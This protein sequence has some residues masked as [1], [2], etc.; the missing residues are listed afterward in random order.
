MK[1]TIPVTLSNFAYILDEDAYKKLNEY[2]EGIR[3]HFSITDSKE[4]TDEIIGDIESSIAEKFSSKLND[5]KQVISIEDVVELVK[6]MGSVEDIAG[7]REDVRDKIGE[8]NYNKNEEKTEKGKKK[9]LFRD[10]DDVII[11]GVASGLASYFGVDSVF[12][13]LLFFVS[14]FFGGAGVVIYVI[15]W[16]V[17]PKA[18]TS[19]QKL[20]MQGDSVTLKQ[21]EKLAREKT[22]E[23][24]N[25]D[26]GKIKNFIN[27]IFEIIGKI[28][29]AFWKVF[30]I[31]WA[32]LGSFI[33][34]VI[35]VVSTLALTVVGFVLAAMVFNSDSPF[36]NMPEGLIETMGRGI[37]PLAAF[38][39]V[40]VPIIFLI[41]L[42]A[43]LVGRRNVFNLPTSLT[44]IA[45][46]VTATIV[47]GVVG[48]DTIPEIKKQIEL[49]DSDINLITNDVE[50][51]SFDRIKVGAAYK[52]NIT[53][54]DEYK[55]TAKG[56]EDDLEKMNVSVIEG[57]LI[58]KRNQNEICLFCH[59]GNNV[60]FE[61]TTPSLNNLEASG[62]SSVDVIGFSGELIQAKFSGASKGVLD[63]NYGKF[64]MDLSGASKLILNTATS[65]EL[66]I[67]LS[68]AS[69]A[70]ISGVADVFKVYMSGASTLNSYK[71]KT[72]S[73]KLELSGASKAELSVSRDLDAN[74]SGAS[75]VYYE[76]NPEINTNEE[77]SI[78]LNKEYS[79]LY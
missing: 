16:L 75:T 54:G 27:S 36:I 45:I 63:L 62:A 22:E 58:I 76:G 53:A 69:N 41:L 11:A 23:F 52:A 38:F 44:L 43:S 47:F 2:I 51:S 15:L 78:I 28:L 4:T 3:S 59:K 25:I 73:A 74:V 66:K 68:G 31:F 24:K 37:L 70:E 60:T 10:T 46:W 57:E 29:K 56:R 35:I 30:M 8:S 7:D 40:F 64:D 67:K 33:G 17:V 39:V 71:L 26:R 55:V 77:R 34:G 21:L 65:T 79:E 13:R 49:Y 48:I 1:K 50:V 32:A 61:I 18:K 6:L 12:V 5:S 19:T 72:M 14:M 42:G 9:R 20:E